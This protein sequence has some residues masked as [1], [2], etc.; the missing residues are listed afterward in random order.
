M[1]EG[2]NRPALAFHSVARPL[3]GPQGLPIRHP[4]GAKSTLAVT[5]ATYTVVPFPGERPDVTAPY[6]DT[7]PWL[8]AGFGNAATTYGWHFYGTTNYTDTR[9]NNV[10]A[11]DDSLAINAPGRFAASTTTGEPL[12]FNYVPDFT[13]APT[14]GKNRRAATVNLFYWNNLMHDVLYQ[15]GFTEAAGN[16]Q[17]DN[18]G[19]GGTG[20]DYVHTETQ[21][22]GG[23]NNANFNTPPDG[24]SGRMQMYLFNLSTGV[25]LVVAAPAVIAGIYPTVEGTIS[26]QNKLVDKGPTSGVLVYMMTRLRPR[27]WRAPRPLRPVWS[28][29]LPSSTGALAPLSA[30]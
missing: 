4:V 23:T 9:G 13:Q 16:F 24:I 5:P 14:L 2:P 28:A 20:G 12:T 11:Y 18:Q 27:T 17:T 21:D 8:R 26:T 7:N 6:T 29:K 22:G 1:Q 3:R 30:R 10:W 15:Y 19:R 25:D